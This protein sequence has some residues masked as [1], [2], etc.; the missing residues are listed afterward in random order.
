MELLNVWPSVFGRNYPREWMLCAFSGM[1][2][3]IILPS[4]WRS[5][6]CSTNASGQEKELLAIVI[7][8]DIINCVIACVISIFK[9]FVENDRQPILWPRRYIF[10]FQ[11]YHEQCMCGLL[12]ASNN[13]VRGFRC[14]THNEPRTCRRLARCTACLKVQ[15]STNCVLR[16]PN[17]DVAGL[18]NND[19]NVAHSSASSG[20]LCVLD[21]RCRCSRQA[22]WTQLPEK[23]VALLLL[24]Q[25]TSWTH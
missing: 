14:F 7:S 16:Q 4:I 8:I 3:L 15:H 5:E 23:W 9:H 19:E 25:K 12:S 13:E 24:L 10:V 1:L 21:C 11:V 17:S 18:S 20:G 2:K 6:N 22:R